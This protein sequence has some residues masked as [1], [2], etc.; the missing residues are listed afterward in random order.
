MSMEPRFH[1]ALLHPEIGPNTGNIGRLSLGVGARL[2]LIHP[3]GF[4]TDEKAVRRAGL[5]YWKSVDVQEHPDAGAFFAWLGARPL[6]LFSARGTQTYTA[7]PIER[8]CVL[9]FG[10]ESTGLPDALVQQHGAWRIPLE[11]AV[12]SLNLANAVSVVA[13]HALSRVEPGLF[14]LD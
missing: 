8:G 2:H 9:L 6:H 12:R 14:D 1:I 5:D 13:Y 10:R 4:R 7:C 3:L 11:P